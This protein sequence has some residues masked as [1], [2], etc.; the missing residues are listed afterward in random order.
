MKK[1][2]KIKMT[3]GLIAIIMLSVIVLGTDNKK[4]ATALSG[5]MQSFA[6]E[7]E[8]SNVKINQE[9]EKYFDTEDA[10]FLQ[11]KLE[12][13]EKQ[14]QA[15]QESQRIE[16]NM[17]IMQENL[18]NSVTILKNG[19][20]LGEEAYSVNMQSG[21]IEIQ[22]EKQESATY[23][24]IYEYTK[25]E[26]KEQTTKL[27]TSVYVKLEEQEETQTTDEKDIDLQEQIGSNI[28]YIEKAKTEI[29]KG[30]IYEKKN[31]T[32]YEQNYNLEISETK[33]IENLQISGESNEKTYYKQTTLN[34]DN[35]IEIFGEDFEIQI[36][37]DNKEVVAILN[38]DSEVDENG[39]IITNYEN[40]NQI[41]ID[42]TKPV[43][44]GELKIRNKKAITA[45]TGYTREEIKNWVS[46]DEKITV[47]ENQFE[48]KNELKETT[49][50]AK[51][52]LSKQE[53]ATMTKNENVELDV[54]LE[55]N[56]NTQDLYKNPTIK[57]EFPQDVEEIE[58]NNISKLYGDEF[59]IAKVYK[60]EENGK[61]YIF[62]QLQG[63]QTEY[64]EK[65]IGGTK[66][67]INA[68]IILNK[69]VT[70]KKD[71]LKLTYTNEISNG[72][73]D[74]QGEKSLEISIVSPKEI[75][76]TNNISELG[77][78]TIG[79]DK[80]VDK[81]IT[82]GD[83][84]K[85]IKVESEIISNCDSKVKDVAILGNFA[86]D[87]TVTIG[88]TEKQ[89]NIGATV[90]T[91]ITIQGA[92]NKEIQIYYTENSNPDTNLNNANNQW[93]QDISTLQNP[94]KYL[95]TIN[96]LSKDETL[97][98]SYEE[99]IPANLQ[100][101]QQAFQGYSISYTKEYSNE[102][103]VV[104]ATTL[105][106]N[107]GKGPVIQTKVRAITGEEELA[108]N[109]KVKQGETIKY[110][111]TVKNVGTEKGSN[112]SVTSQIPEGTVFVEP[113]EGSAYEFGE[114]YEE[115]SS[116]KQWQGKI[117]SLEVNE[118]KELYYE[119]RVKNTTQEGFNI[120][121]N[122]SSTVNDVT[123]D[124]DNFILTVESGTLRV[125]IK[126]NFDGT[127]MCEDDSVR[128][129]GIVENL[130]DK[131]VENAKI[132]WNISD[133]FSIK[134]L[135]IVTKDT[136]NSSDGKNYN[137]TP[138]INLGTIPANGKVVVSLDVT[139][140][141]V[142]QKI[143]NVRLTAQ[144]EADKKY[145]SNIIEQTVKGI[146]LLDFNIS[147]TQEGEYIKP[148]DEITYTI[149]AK[150]INEQS[151]TV[152]VNDEI[153]DELTIKKVGFLLDGQAVNGEQT[154]NSL[155]ITS[156]VEAEKEIV[157]K[158]V[159][160]VDRKEGKN[161]K[162][163][164]T[165]QATGTILYKDKKSNT[166]SHTIEYSENVTPTPTPN[167]DDNLNDN[168]KNT[169]NISGKVWLDENQNGQ[170]DENEQNIDGTKVYLMNVANGE[171]VNTLSATTK[172]T[173]DQ[174][175]E[176]ELVGINPGKYLV[177]FDYNS[178]EYA[179]TTYKAEGID[180]N[181]NSKAI[182]KKTTINDVN[183]TY[184]VT[185]AIE[186]TNRSVGNIN[187]GLIKTKKFDLKL[188][189]YVS[190]IRVKTQKGEA[191]Y[192]YNKSKL[193]KVEVNAKQVDG[194]QAYIEYTIVIT[195]NGEIDGY[196]RQIIDYIPEGLT[197]AT[198][199]NKNWTMKGSNLYNTSLTNEKIKPGETKTVTLLL[200]KTGDIT[201]TYTNTAEIGE[202]Y[203]EQGVDDINSTPGN[204]KNGENDMSTAQLIISVSTGRIFLYIVLI[205]TIIA[206][207]ACGV[208]AIKKL[209][210]GRRE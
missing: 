86:T 52:E 55:S 38:K 112:I 207:I 94:T 166:V 193:A 64:K 125:S 109:A 30:N 159:A 156:N 12:I 154:G 54:T 115:N 83:K 40:V 47:N 167:P 24:L 169:Y 133:V 1:T 106:I 57:L 151:A 121:N 198:E 143:E 195:N 188:D 190:K 111:A 4:I 81:E 49:T 33:D 127:S 152:T 75:I 51:L 3:I 19:K 36:K 84:Q 113:I 22:I 79:E 90:K 50:Q 200:R 181:K 114:Y 70:N 185:D 209:V 28:S 148:G 194:A 131:D 27:K 82:R 56:N 76:T 139:A 178:S 110:V 117:D 162:V 26:N 21:N 6:G 196:A 179:L 92:E 105:N 97:T 89:N 177:I 104:D 138:E 153:P 161:E 146:K 141:N 34:K 9:I 63:E 20:K 187:V 68:N 95:I 58:V 78:E 69:K 160:T 41:E 137:R 48:T 93:T 44:S 145:N 128:Y 122:F 2:M 16:I 164:I 168:N 85:T 204:Q 144:V 74:E 62:L 135:R 171:I 189:K 35:L 5:M 120:T 192:S 118:T 130:T 77:I 170:L 108:T 180:S 174:N 71:A 197:L 119:V 23:K 175:G 53:W 107:T 59:E 158:I 15:K 199:E 206:I 191:V 116:K 172:S 183:K 65:A 201:G 87:G 203:N 61:K 163:V 136:I 184:G 72:Y 46:L 102:N 66:I 186:I 39:N 37:N 132:K 18:P 147:A 60:A 99:E 150:N 80:V 210:L 11:Q 31:E 8:E 126:P 155:S 43:N 124:S 17:P 176:Y 129:E 142:S 103:G 202:S 173:T 14:T 67:V 165:N 96:D 182:S 25:I 101:N 149:T 91:P 157:I 42:S 32:E 123:Q 140:E 100:Y 205:I 73:E 88:N 98:S 10:T 29:Y 13:T 208:C 7:Q 134:D 45:D